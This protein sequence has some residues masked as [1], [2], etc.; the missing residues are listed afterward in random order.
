METFMPT[1]NTHPGERTT[2]S[3]TTRTTKNNA[4]KLMIEDH[5]KVKK[6]FKEFENYVKR[7]M[8]RERSACETD[9]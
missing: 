3:T 4:I 2:R 5:D 8:P 6:M 9:L 7:E 1:A